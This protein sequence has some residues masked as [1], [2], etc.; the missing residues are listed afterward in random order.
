MNRGRKNYRFSQKTL[1][2][3]RALT[4][5]YEG[6]LTETDIVEQAIQASWEAIWERRWLKAADAAKTYIQEGEP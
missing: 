2:S 6:R 1:E 5:Y 3:L 4:D